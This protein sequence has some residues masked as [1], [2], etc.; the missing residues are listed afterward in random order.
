MSFETP[1]ALWGLL[2]LLLLALF[3]LWRQAAVR[4]VV[5]SLLLWKRIPERNP[6]IRALRRPAFRWD[7]LA[8]ALALA[9]AVGALAGPFLT[10]ERPRP[11]RIGIVLDASARMRGRFDRLIERARELQRGPLAGDRVTFYAADPSPRPSLDPGVFRVVDVHVDPEPLLA[12][13]RQE[14]ERVVLFSD[15]LR[16][17]I[18]VERF[19]GPAGNLGIVEFSASDEE[20]FARIVNHGPARPAALA[21]TIDGRRTERRVDLP[22]GERGW[23]EKGDYSKAAAITLS[24]PGGDGF[25][26]DDVAGAVRFAPAETPVSVRGRQVPL[27]QRA[28]AAVPGVVLR[29][30]EAVVAVGVDESPG[31]G[32]LKVRCYE[33]DSPRQADVVVHPHPLTEGLRA[34]E[35]GSSGVGEL[36]AEAVG[37]TPLLSAGGRPVA[38]LKGDTLHVA[39]SLSPKAWPSTPSFPIFWSNVIHFARKG[40]AELAVPRT[41][42]EFDVP[43]PGGRLLVHAAGEQSVEGLRFWV[44]LLDD[45]ESDVEGGAGAVE[46]TSTP[47]GPSDLERRSLGGGGAGLALAFVILAWVL[48]RRTE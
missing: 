44:G 48:Q 15:R 21:V 17:G 36:P 38:A 43:G 35:I 40:R 5:P 28:L 25:A 41:G 7:L 47:R 4:T 27:L 3:S 29:A 6:P 39:V 1:A 10:T 24:L 32:A 13:A 19:A 37:G 11:R 31:P 34:A 16:P 8:Y 12:V 46:W 33:P 9:S 30:G 26:T 2:S 42:R 18:E 14:N 23:S 22:A 45:R 20:L